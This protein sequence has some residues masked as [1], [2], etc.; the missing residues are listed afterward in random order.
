MKTVYRHKMLALASITTVLVAVGVAR[1]EV[2]EEF[3]H[4]YPLG[5]QGRVQLENVNGDVRVVTWDRVEIKVDA[6][7]RAKKQEHLEEVKIQV[8][9][10]PDRIH[11]KTKYPDSK[12]RRNKNNSTSVDYTLTVPKQSRL[13][14]I[15]TVN[16][17]IEIERAGGDVDASSVNGSVKAI[18]LSGE[19]QLSTVNGSVK[20]SFGELKKPISVNSVNGG[21]SIALPAD[22]NADISAHTLNGGISSEFPVQVKKHFPIGQNLDGKL[23]N[24]GPTVKMSTVNGGIHIDRSATVGLDN[25]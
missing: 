24:G 7:K 17:G 6:I 3:H 25:R 21:V 1:G 15:S 12:T 11:I 19:T 20:A 13:G 10:D 4:S 14:K 2:R 9:S 18:G 16:G 22:T 23:G 8:D 5:A